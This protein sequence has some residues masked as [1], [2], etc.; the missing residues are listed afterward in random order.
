MRWIALYSFLVP[1]WLISCPIW[2]IFPKN[3]KEIYPLLLF[4]YLGL[5]QW[6]YAITYIHTFK[7]GCGGLTV[8]NLD[9]IYIY[10]HLSNSF[11]IFLIHYHSD[12]SLDGGSYG[13][14]SRSLRFGNHINQLNPS[15]LLPSFLHYSY[16]VSLSYIDIYLYLSIYISISLYIPTFLI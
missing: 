12:Q 2:K 15:F 16:W 6:R 5:H 3:Y 7:V 14:Y 10:I 11:N 9:I 13:Y 1:S 4:P 8:F